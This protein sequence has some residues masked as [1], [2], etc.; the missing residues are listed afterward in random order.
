MKSHRLIYIDNLRIFLI[1][2]VVLHHLA[3]TYGAPGSWYY[4]EGQAGT[5]A[6]ILL[7]MFVASNQSFFMGLLFFIS[8]YFA[9]VS[10][11]NKKSFLPARIKRLGIPLLLYFFFLSPLTI[12]LGVRFHRN[13]DISFFEFIKNSQGFGFGPMWFVEVLLIFAVIY[14]LFRALIPGF[15]ENRKSQQ[16]P[17]NLAIILLV[18]FLGVFSFVARLG[19]PVGWNLEPFG[20]QL[21]FFPQYI[22]MLLLG[23][24][25]HQ[26]GWLASLTF[27]RSIG[28][29]VFAQA[30][31]F[32]VFPV[33]FGIGG[34]AK[35]NIEPFMGGMYY[36]S[37]LYSIWEQFTG[38]SLMIGVLGIFQHKFSGQKKLIAQLS[39]CS[40]AVYVFHPPIVVG[41]ALSVKMISLPLLLKFVVLAIPVLASCFIFAC[42]IRKLP[43]ARK[44]F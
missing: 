43:L 30:M 34:A 44:I 1:S 29:F 37:F 3:I 33:I 32:I 14:V 13:V 22:A 21:G 15:M 31:I 26:R 35:G 24:L 16:M 36:Q 18:S 42:L 11:E 40:F 20:F 25:A 23:V 2:L 27:K 38:I 39:S 28:W 5:P 19:F 4:N 10:F 9:N 12:Y 8:A 6:A 7:S 17:N 41:I